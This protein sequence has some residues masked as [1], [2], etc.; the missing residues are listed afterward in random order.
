[1]ALS[2][3]EFREVT[4]SLGTKSCRDFP[5]QKWRERSRPMSRLDWPRS[6]ERDAG[7]RARPLPRPNAVRQVQAEGM[8]TK[9]VDLHD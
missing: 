1:M 6:A 8:L 2:E 5:A 4:D 3:F 7:S 9:T